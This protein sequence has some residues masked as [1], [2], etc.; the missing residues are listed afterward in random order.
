[1][2]TAGE[3]V[4][5]PTDTVYGVAACATNPDATASIF[6]IKR[7]SRKNPLAILAATAE[8]AFQL[9]EFGEEA[10]A[11]ALAGWPGALTVVVPRSPRSLHL[12]LGGDGSSIGL[13]VPDSDFV[14][15]VIDAAGLLAATSANRSGEAT[16][17]SIDAIVD[18]LGDQV[19]LFVDGGDLTGDA[20]RVVSFLGAT[21]T[22]RE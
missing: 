9:G 14:R 2:L 18:D 11:E 16:P 10:R 15:E 17:T 22:L 5:I 7:R 19:A 21:K 3:V 13:R 4:I 20:S 12:S 8:Q 1:M 6:T